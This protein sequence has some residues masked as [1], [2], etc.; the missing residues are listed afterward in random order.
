MA[1]VDENVEELRKYIDKGADVNGV[2][3]AGKGTSSGTGNVYVR[4]RVWRGTRMIVGMLSP[5]LK[6]I[7]HAIPGPLHYA[8]WKSSKKTGTEMC[9]TLIEAG[10][11]VDAVDN[12]G[13]TVRAVT[14]NLLLALT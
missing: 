11:V 4:T 1:V 13:S 8:A 6:N 2:D 5:S 9:S 7:H 10:A 12:F 3:A 14:L